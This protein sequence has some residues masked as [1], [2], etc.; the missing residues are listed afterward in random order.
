M[1][2]PRV[3]FVLL[4]DG[5]FKV[6]NVVWGCDL[7]SFNQLVDPYK[8]KG[9]NFGVNSLMQ[10]NISV[11]VLFHELNPLVHCKAGTSSF[12]DTC[13]VEVVSD[14]D[15]SVNGFP[16]P[17]PTFATGFPP[18]S[19]TDSWVEQN[20]RDSV[21]AQSISL[22]SL[23]LDSDEE[24]VTSSLPIASGH[25]VSS[26]ESVNSE[27]VSVQETK[28]DLLSHSTVCS[29]N[30]SG[31][32]EN[33]NIHH[34]VL[35]PSGNTFTVPSSDNNSRVS[36][37]V[38]QS[39]NYLHRKTDPQ[40]RSES[41]SSLDDLHRRGSLDDNKELINIVQCS[42]SSDSEFDYKFDQEYF[43]HYNN[44]QNS[45]SLKL[46][47]TN[48]VVHTFGNWPLDN[49]KLSRLEHKRIYS[50]PIDK[51]LDTESQIIS[52]ILYH[53]N[54]SSYSN[55]KDNVYENSSSTCSNSAVSKRSDRYIR[56]IDVLEVAGVPFSYEDVVYSTNEE[57][58]HLRATR[59][60]TE[61]QLTAMSD[62]R[63]RATNRQAAERCR[64]SKV[65]ARDELAE[66]LADLRLQRQ[67]LNKRLVK[68]RQRKRDTRDNLTEEQNRLLHMLHDS[69]GCTLKPSDW[70]IHLTTEDEIVV[71]SVGH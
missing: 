29:R 63:R 45:R 42:S 57:F 50:E 59:G 19:P 64:R 26:V 54:S 68:A 70:R 41:S 71:V 20:N 5:Y 4:S 65:A 30:C 10:I 56:D 34:Q 60:L 2:S 66:R 38:T 8:Q 22:L 6:K 33:T 7:V 51:S 53:Q 39:V 31:Y 69:N 49:S 1:G 9:L 14:P 46:V 35:K 18:I 52:P 23:N 25:K 43:I 32:G 11:F 21:D 16:S 37:V 17:S 67:A 12:V 44:L 24:K 27:E 47:D 3:F 13:E 62:A 48:S 61:E 40:L 28:V 15:I 36:D 55:S 58:R